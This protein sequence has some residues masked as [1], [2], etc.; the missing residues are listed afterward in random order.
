ML[1]WVGHVVY[2]TLQRRYYSQLGSWCSVIML[3]W[4]GGVVYVT[5]H[6]QRHYSQLVVW[7]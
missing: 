2:V 6:H 5:L 7:Y 4:V 1:S 3:S